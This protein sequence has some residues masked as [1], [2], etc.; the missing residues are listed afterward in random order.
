MLAAQESWQKSASQQIFHSVTEI[1]RQGDT[2]Q[3]VWFISSGEV[4]LVRMESEGQ[5]LIVNLRSAGRWLGLAS[6]IRQARYDFTALPLTKC[7]LQ[8]LPIGTFRRILKADLEFAR[9]I[10]R[11]LA[12]NII[13]LYERATQ[14]ANITARQRLEQYLWRALK[15][16]GLNGNGD[17]VRLRLPRNYK[18]IARMVDV[19]PQY[20]SELL[21][22]MEEEGL[23]RRDGRNLTI[24]DRR[25]L[26]HEGDSEP[27]FGH[28][29]WSGEKTA[30]GRTEK[31]ETEKWQTEK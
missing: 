3:A 19:T 29:N 4:K 20:I 7:S 5:Q 21:K 22:E 30:Q 1:F 28:R 18:E 27:S 8:C 13:E 24:V 31:C 6:A 9:L 25:R 17:E 15:E 14:I 10:A 23:L 12:D 11:A 26:W 2:P 16:R